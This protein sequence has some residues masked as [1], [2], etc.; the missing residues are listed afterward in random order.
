MLLNSRVMSDMKS[1]PISHQPFHSLFYFVVCLFI[2]FPVRCV[3]IVLHHQCLILSFPS[4]HCSFE[5]QSGL[6][7]RG[8]EQSEGRSGGGEKQMSLDTRKEGERGAV[9]ELLHDETQV[10]CNITKN[11]D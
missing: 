9:S 5:R 6:K 1:V 2:K 7:H 10:R 3:V 11:Q 8:E 4:S